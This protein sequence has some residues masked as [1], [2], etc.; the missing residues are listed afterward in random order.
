[1]HFVR[2]KTVQVAT[3]WKGRGGAAIALADPVYLA[4]ADEGAMR[5][6]IANRCAWN[7]D[8]GLRSECWR[9][10]YRQTD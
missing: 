7:R 1:M 5:K 2:A 3:V 8:A 10:A 4:I 6:V 9:N